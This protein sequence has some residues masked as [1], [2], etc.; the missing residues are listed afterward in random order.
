MS[1]TLRIQAI[2]TNGAGHQKSSGT[3]QSTSGGNFADA[4]KNAEVQFSRHAQKRLDVRNIHLNEDSLTRLTDA[5][6]RVGR[7]G[8]KDSLVLMDDLAFI[9][10]VPER[11]VVTAVDAKTRGEGVFTQIDSVVLADEGNKKTVLV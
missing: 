5:I 6:D 4:L 7:R 8:G 3:V 10:N 2:R 1:D 11:R 9:V